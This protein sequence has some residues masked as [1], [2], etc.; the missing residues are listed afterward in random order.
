ME[1][2][3]PK[4]PYCGTIAKLVDSKVI[5]KTKSYGK[6][7]VC[8][9]Y[10]TCDAYCGVHP[11]DRPLGQLANKELRKAR[12]IAHKNFDL[13]WME[14]ARRTSCSNKDARVGGYAWLAK[15]LKIESKDCHIGM[16]DVAMCQKVT[17]ICE[18]YANKI[19]SNAAKRKTAP[20]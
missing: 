3:P 9:N 1:L 14:K 7:W 5:Y 20:S 16:M 10:P 11:N 13:L 12:E 6:A 17:A 2:T 19:T 4:C 15:Q 18:P 8:G